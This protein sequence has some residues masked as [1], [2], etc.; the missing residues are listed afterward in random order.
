MCATNAAL[1][2]A[3]KHRHQ[4][5]A[6]DKL[7]REEAPILDITDLIDGDDVRVVERGG[8]ARFLFEAAKRVG[9]A[10]QLRTEQLHGDLSLE[11]AILR[12]VHLAHA[13]AA[14]EREDLVGSRP[15][16]QR[17]GIAGRSDRPGDVNRR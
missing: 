2:R 10:R 6:F 16:A 3:T 13:A 5:L 4:R 15:S 17:A 8:G 7:H 12:E 1:D 11:A 14:D 9:V